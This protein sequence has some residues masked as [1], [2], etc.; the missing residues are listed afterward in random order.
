MDTTTAPIALLDPTA[1]QYD[2]DAERTQ[3]AAKNATF[4][5]AFNNGA[6]YNIMLDIFPDGMSERPSLYYA[7]VCLE[8]GPVL[9][10][11]LF[12]QAAGVKFNPP[13]GEYDE[14]DPELLHSWLVAT[15]PGHS[16]PGLVNR[17]REPEPE[18]EPLVLPQHEQAFLKD[19]AACAEARAWLVAGQYPTLE[20]AWQ[21]C[22]RG[23]W[24]LWLLRESNTPSGIWRHLAVDFA[25]QV[26]HL[27]T[28]E[29]S[30][31]ALQVARR[32]ADGQASDEELSAARAAAGDAA[33]DAARD[34]QADLLRRVCAEVDTP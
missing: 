26:R 18:P 8:D 2:D 23:D 6:A 25:E 27:M 20:A 7:L 24:M 3:Y 16:T 33:W 34:V 5:A 28:D 11:P 22:Q 4:C 17:L 13:C 1:I 9:P 12:E 30:R 19:H 29:R 32:Y 14:F 31:A 10:L 15:F 21:V